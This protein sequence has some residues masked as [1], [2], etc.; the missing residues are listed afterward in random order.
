[1]VLIETINGKK[2]E[3]KPVNNLYKEFAL[4]R[5]AVKDLIAHG[6]KVKSF[7]IQRLV[8]TNNEKQQALLKDLSLPDELS[9]WSEP[10]NRKHT[11]HTVWFKG[12]SLDKIFLS[13]T[14]LLERLREV[15]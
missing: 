15:E 4:V 12:D 14:V 7:S 9:F 13:Y 3:I 6:D 5:E 2:I 11:E 1:M 8:K 10:L